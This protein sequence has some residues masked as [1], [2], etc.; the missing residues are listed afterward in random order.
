MR[1]WI[2]ASLVLLLLVAALVLAL[3]NLNSYVSRGAYIARQAGAAL[4]R[5]VSFDAVGLSVLRGFG[6]SVDGL[7]I[8]E[9]P[10]VAGGDFVQAHRVLITLEPLPLLWKHFEITHIVLDHPTVNIDRKRAGYNFSSLGKPS[11]TAANEERIASGRRSP[12]RLFVSTVD[13]IGAEV[14][15]RDETATPATEATVQNLDASAADVSLIVSQFPPGTRLSVEKV[16]LNAF[17]GTCSARGTFDASTGTP[18]FDCESAIRAMRLDGLLPIWFPGAKGRMTGELD[19][20][21]SVRGS[22][23]GWEAI[24]STLRGS[25]RMEV[26]N[27]TLKDVNLAEAVLRGLTGIRGLS[28]FVSKR[29]RSK[30]PEI[31]GTRDTS[32]ATLSGTV[33][34]ADER[35]TTDDLTLAARGYTVV[36]KGSV[37]LDNQVDFTAT[38]LVSP[39]LTGDIVAGF[40]EAKSLIGQEGR[41][42]VPF[43]LRGRLPSPDAKPDSDVVRMLEQ[44]VIEKGLDSLLHKK[45]S[46][47]KNLLR[48]ALKGLLGK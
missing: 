6:V 4:G 24:R 17:G 11:G 5:P 44:R 31:F 2:V 15:Y 20:D 32:F 30:Y 13:I 1:R 36:G 48:K 18:S 25:G 10:N 7:H 40:P 8:A 41:L 27:G 43:T 45:P 29:V 14:R 34:I 28:S 23:R 39:E 38:L 42:R 22:G 21:L 37:R 19:A 33:A 9:D 35:V 3:L 16:D 26:K 12:L 47:E 46:A